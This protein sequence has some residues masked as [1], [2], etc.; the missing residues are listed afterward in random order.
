LILP[1][2]HSER[3]EESKAMFATQ[4]AAARSRLDPSLRSG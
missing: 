3:S 1:T 2:R 4:K